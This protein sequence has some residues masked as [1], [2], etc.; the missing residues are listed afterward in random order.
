VRRLFQACDRAGGIQRSRE[1]IRGV[2]QTGQSYE[3]TPRT[4]L[5]GEDELVRKIQLLG[6][7]SLRRTFFQG[8]LRN[9]FLEKG[10]H[11]LKP[12]SSVAFFQQSFS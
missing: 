11:P 8:V 4:F 2:I 3:R 1:V 7:V 9:L 6:V 5:L 10:T 12:F